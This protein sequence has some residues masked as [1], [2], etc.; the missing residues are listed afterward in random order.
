MAVQSRDRHL[1]SAVMT[2]VVNAILGLCKWPVA[3]VSALLLPGTLIA[4]AHT[5]DRA[6]AGPAPPWPLV[7][8]LLGYG[9]IWR[10]FLRTRHSAGVFSTLEHE[11]TH[12]LFALC[13]FHQVIGLKTTATQGGQMQFRGGG[14]W[15]IAVAPYFFPS[16]AV[17]ITLLML[18]MHDAARYWSTAA[19]GA[20][21]AYHLISTYRQL[22]W[23]QTDLQ[24]VGFPFAFT[25]LPNANLLIYG[26]IL[27][28]GSGGL[29]L[30]RYFLREVWQASLGVLAATGVA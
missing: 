14:N 13:T 17:A 26:L 16:L 15:L 20:S 21:I 1:S 11:L 18:L 2:R 10:A 23:G 22:H 24:K 7:A 25:F 27:S 5:A 4:W 19:L 9:L 29:E 6:L 30:A 12:T 28:L 3:L 8:G